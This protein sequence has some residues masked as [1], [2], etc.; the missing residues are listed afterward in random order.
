M[1]IERARVRVHQVFEH[2]LGGDLIDALQHALVALVEKFRDLGPLFVRQHQRQRIVLHALTPRLVHVSRG[3][4]PCRVLTIELEGLVRVPIRFGLEKVE[5]V[6]H[7]LAV[8][9]LEAREDEER[10]VDVARADH[11]VELQAIGL[12]LGDVGGQEVAA[13]AVEEIQEPLKDLLG[14]L[15]VDRHAAVVGF[16]QNASDLAR[17]RAVRIRGGDGARRKNGCAGR[18]LHGTGYG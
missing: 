18:G 10:R 15:V 9:L 12:E 13:L 1:R 8:A 2:V 17:R 5:R 7:T 4:G 11:V 16:L 6:L 3:G 14:E